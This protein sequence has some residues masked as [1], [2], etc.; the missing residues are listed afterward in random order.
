MECCHVNGNRRS[1]RRTG[2]WKREEDGKNRG[3]LAGEP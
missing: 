1:I 2:D 3:L